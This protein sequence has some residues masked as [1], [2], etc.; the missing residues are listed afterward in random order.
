MAKAFTLPD[1]GEGVETGD[2]L[3]VLVAVG[4][5]ISAGQAVVELETGKATVEVPCDVAGRVEEV[6]VAEGDTIA[7]GATI[8]KVA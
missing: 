3:K 6:L 8:L 7:V 1:L 4:D 5:V 2:V